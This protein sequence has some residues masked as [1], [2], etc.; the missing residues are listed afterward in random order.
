MARITMKCPCCGDEMKFGADGIT[1]TCESCWHTEYWKEEKSDKVISE[2][3]RANALR[4][5]NRFSDAIMEYRLIT[6]QNPDDAEAHWGLVLSLY[7]IE[8]VKDP[9]TGRYTPTCH[10]TVRESILENGDYLKA[11]ECASDDQVEEYRTQ[12]AEINRL[13]KEILK[14]S[15][16]EEEYDVFISFKSTDERGRITRDAQIARI[17]YDELTKRGV[18]TFFSDVTLEG[19]LFSA[20]EP[21]IYRALFSCK[22]FILVG[23][24]DEFIHAPWVKNEWS[25][26]EERMETEK[27]SG[28]ACAVFDGA[29]VK[30]LPPFARTQGIDLRRYAAGGYEIHVAD[31]VEK[32]L[33]RKKRS[34]EE[35]EILQQIEAQKKAQRELEERLK[36]LQQGGAESAGGGAS[37]TVKSLL[38]RAGQELEVKSW[39]NARDYY[40]RVLDADPQNADAWWGL[41][42]V[43]RNATDDKGA[44]NSVDSK[45]QFDEVKHNRNYMSALRYATGKTAEKIE[46][47]QKNL[48]SEESVLPRADKFLKKKQFDRAENVY[49]LLLDSEPENAKAWWGILLCEE[50]CASEEEFFNKSD[51]DTTAKTVKSTAYQNAYNFAQGEFREHLLDL[52]KKIAAGFEPKAQECREKISN[53]GNESDAKLKRFHAAD[54]ELS[55]QIDEVNNE[56]SGIF[57][58]HPILR[59]Y[60]D[61]SSAHVPVLRL[62]IV[63]C[64]FAVLAAIGW[65]VLDMLV[66]ADMPT[67]DMGDFADFITWGIDGGTSSFPLFIIQG[68]IYGGLFGIGFL[69]LILILAGI[70]A[71]IINA[72]NRSKR[73][74]YEKASWLLG[75][76]TKERDDL[77]EKQKRQKR[78]FDQVIDNINRKQR[79]EQRKLDNYECFIG[80]NYA[81][82]IEYKEE[83][84]QAAAAVASAPAPKKKGKKNAKTAD[85]T[86]NI[87]WYVELVSC[88]PNKIDVIKL[89]RT[90]LGCGLAEGKAMAEKGGV[91]A[92]D[93]DEE[94]ASSLTYVLR[95]MGATVKTGA[96]THK[97]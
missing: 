85:A 81:E 48:T 62:L 36:G 41:F 73:G 25:R 97:N 45:A 52:R 58:A 49:R 5:A 38:M 77:N 75:K 86:G 28:V 68:L 20:F 53:Y 79:G 9:R 64:V 90:F 35:E 31:A 83:P 74:S 43:D 60:R 93:L 10:R 88:G 16:A 87:M 71:G 57:S 42:L 34:K 19:K 22:F 44:E 84:V 47:F 46:A 33:G 59:T 8:F 26:F 82:M 24:K 23:T 15:D 6:E 69:I 67:Y 55:R 11:V 39:D 21:I 29:E 80:G 3:D 72:K 2:L 30:N 78:E 56:I 63:A 89:L 14:L 4:R 96:M 51:W 27:L 76:S 95:S 7:G 70:G 12:A 91:I 65:M 13:Q 37:A 32:K 50:E 1:L 17:I 61:K 94:N 54:A 18:K 66:F 40:G 92:S